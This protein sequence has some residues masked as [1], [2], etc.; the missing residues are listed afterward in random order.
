MP[1]SPS[2]KL[3]IVAFD[4]P[5]PADYGGAIDVYYKLAALHRKGCAIT[6]HCFE[7]GR[8]HAAQLEKLC[9]AVHY[10]P[11]ITGLN[12]LR[13]PLP[14]IVSSRRNGELMKNL[15]EDDAPILFEGIHTC[16]YL[17]HQALQNRFKALRIHNIE[18]QYYMQLA[19][20]VG[21][22]FRKMFFLQE[23]RMLK[24]FEMKLQNVQAF[25]ALS[26]TDSEFFRAIYPD[27]VHRFVSP[28]HRHDVVESTPGMGAFCLYHGNL[29]HP[30]NVTAAKFLMDEVVPSLKMRL[31][32]AGK[33]PHPSI[34]AR[35]QESSNCELVADPDEARMEQLIRDAHI[36]VLPTFQTSGMKLKL[37]HALYGGRFVVVNAAM[38]HGSGLENACVGAQTTKEFIDTCNG[39]LDKPF[40]EVDLEYR[41]NVLAGY[42]NLANSGIMMDELGLERQ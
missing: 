4:V 16:F 19:G 8:P 30:E 26:K 1:A 20:G 3:H 18:H 21:F 25:F 28:F 15:L 29:S 33:S 40:T 11:R 17:N 36:H 13:P 27:A 22:G 5:Y 23:A 7:Y 35:C 14:Y 39:L 9:S 37:L 6:L 10:Y 42:G 2:N 31:V 12:G 32:F 34:V 41:R 24:A 38:L